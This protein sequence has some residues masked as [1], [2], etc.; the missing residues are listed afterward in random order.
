MNE[1]AL[2]LFSLAKEENLL[3]VF[4]SEVNSLIDVF[5]DKKI[6]DFF[7]NKF[8]KVKEKKEIVNNTFNGLNK[9]LLNFINIIIDDCKEEN[10]NE[11]FSNFNELYFKEK[12]IVKGIVY[13]LEID[14]DKISKLEETLSNKL[15]KKVI[16]EFKQDI[17]LIGGYKVVVDNKLYD[18]SYKNKLD[19]L[20]NKLLKEGDFSD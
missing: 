4:F 13:G 6:N 16:L 17:S 14:K 7:S 3:D 12:N 9:Y 10:M 11:I 8:I 15:N 19:N 5:K 2:S 1:Y 20:K 18:N